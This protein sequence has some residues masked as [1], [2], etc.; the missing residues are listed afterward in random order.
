MR[1]KPPLADLPGMQSAV[2]RVEKQLGEDG[3][4]LVRYSGTENKLRVMVEGP[5]QDVVV[6]AC[7]VICSAVREEI[8][9]G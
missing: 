3:R 5:T 2:S 6:G 1:E 9:H 7:D 8:G 4:V